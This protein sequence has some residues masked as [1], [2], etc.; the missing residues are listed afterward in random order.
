MQVVPERRKVLGEECELLGY[1]RG[2]GE[3]QSINELLLAEGKAIFNA[4]SEEVRDLELLVR[5]GQAARRES[6]GWFGTLQRDE[7]VDLPYL[8]GAVIG[9]H[10]QEQER[11]YHRQIDE[12]QAAGFQQV[13]FLF[14]AFLADVK[15]WRI[16]RDAQR[17]VSD[18]R[19]LE[20]IAYARS[21][22]L[23][24]MLLPILLLREQNDDDWR[25]T[26]RPQPEEKFWLEYDRF[27]SRYLDLAEMAGVD[28]FS[29]GSELGSMEDRRE[30]WERLILNARARFS[31]FLTYSANWDH[32]ET[33]EF[34]PKLDLVGCTGYFSLTE[35]SDPSREELRLAWRRVAAQLERARERFGRPLFITELG[36]CSQNGSNRDP[37]NYLMDKADLDFQEQ[38]DCFAAFI[39]VA[40]ECESLSGAYFYDYFDLGGLQDHSYSPR[41]KPAMAQWRRWAELELPGRVKRARER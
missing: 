6:R 9:L 24:V 35:D 39:D 2:P 33:A 41:G 38:A 30:T 32:L 28:L 23:R 12:L 34:F 13:S 25:G 27:L 37:W 15:A 3:A 16:E 40:E 8:N 22:G 1:L 21:R 10:Y 29:I 17:S 11:D 19:L 20:S 26:I 36:Y 5:A 18:E 14:A 31:G 4:R 7:L